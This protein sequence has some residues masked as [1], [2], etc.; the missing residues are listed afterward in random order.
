MQARRKRDL[1]VLYSNG[2]ENLLML[3]LKAFRKEQ[4]C[5]R[6]RIGPP[7]LSLPK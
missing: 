7:T 3:K 4:G 6:P 5:K 1:V 2:C